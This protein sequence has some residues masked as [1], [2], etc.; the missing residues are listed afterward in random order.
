MEKL[1]KRYTDLY[2]KDI[3]DKNK[4]IQKL[5]KMLAKFKPDRINYVSKNDWLNVKD[6]AFEIIDQGVSQLVAEDEFEYEHMAYQGLTGRQWVNLP[7]YVKEALNLLTRDKY[8]DW[9]ELNSWNIVN[10]V[11]M[12]FT[13][14]IS[15]GLW[16]AFYLS[17]GP[18]S[19][20]NLIYNNII[21]QIYDPSNNEGIISQ[22][23]IF[24][25]G[26]Y[27]CLS[28]SDSDFEV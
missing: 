8:K 18:D 4:E 19:L 7:E 26:S 10:N 25:D 16:E 5:K 15:C 11:R 14:M 21:L 20:A 13:S 27:L 12:F 2:N 9:A 17:N 24:D 1:I 22:M 6:K 3:Y 28:D 23:F